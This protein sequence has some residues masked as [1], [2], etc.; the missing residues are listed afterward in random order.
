MALPGSD[1]SRWS[2][3]YSIPCRSDCKNTAVTLLCCRLPGKD[4]HNVN[5]LL[6]HLEW[7][8]ANKGTAEDD[9]EGMLRLQPGVL[10]LEVRLEALHSGFQGDVWRDPQPGGSLCCGRGGWRAERA[11]RLCS[12]MASGITCVCVCAGS[13]C[14]TTSVTP[15]SV[16]SICRSTAQPISWAS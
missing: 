3:P 14:T 16:V 9:C 15:S 11:W 2:V 1:V 12:S 5:R 6:T 13:V 8:Q 7:P 10:S 4:R